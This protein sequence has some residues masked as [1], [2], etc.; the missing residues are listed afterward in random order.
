MVQET[1]AASGVKEETAS[2]ATEAMTAEEVDVVVA[3]VVA[4]EVAA[5]VVVV[6]G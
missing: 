3:W 4:R 6:M 2:E 1:L 5:R